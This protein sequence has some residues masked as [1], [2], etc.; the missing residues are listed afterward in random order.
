[1]GWRKLSGML[2]EAGDGHKLARFVSIYQ[3]GIATVHTI[4][5]YLKGNV[6]DQDPEVE[7]TSI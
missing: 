3:T 4:L 2:E 1:M 7:R 6:T 5:F